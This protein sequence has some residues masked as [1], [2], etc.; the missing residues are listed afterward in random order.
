MEILLSPSKFATIKATADF[1]RTSNSSS[2]A[3]LLAPLLSM[4]LRL[5]GCFNAVL[6]RLGGL[7]GS[8]RMGLYCRI[9]VGG[10]AAVACIAKLSP[11]TANKHL[12]RKF[13]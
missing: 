11:I 12:R 10:K 9:C 7:G 1:V 6:V 2:D 5:A 3:L 4:R 13:G 8:S